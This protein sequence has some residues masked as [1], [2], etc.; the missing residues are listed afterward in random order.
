M[1]ELLEKMSS[2]GLSSEE[3][4]SDILEDELYRDL[5]TLAFSELFLLISALE[6]VG[7]GGMVLDFVILLKRGEMKRFFC[8]V[9]FC[10][11][12]LS[13]GGGDMKEILG[14]FIVG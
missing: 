2:A 13:L 7:R 14:V 6:F 8:F 9:V 5:S 1:D 3:N 4:F 11:P 10:D 12:Y